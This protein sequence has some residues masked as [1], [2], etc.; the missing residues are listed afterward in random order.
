[1]SIHFRYLAP[2]TDF[3]RG[4]ASALYVR[5]AECLEVRRTAVQLGEWKPS[6]KRC[7]H[8]VSEWVRCNPTHQA[9]RGWLYFALP[10]LSFVRFT[11]HSVVRNDTGGFFDITPS[12]AVEYPFLQAKISESDFETAVDTLTT[13]F[14]VSHLDHWITQN[15]GNLQWSKPIP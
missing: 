6:A 13:H 8:N 1:M 12:E 11:A 14:G 4:Y 15:S 10:G 2:P 9:V 7:H 5:R 3:L